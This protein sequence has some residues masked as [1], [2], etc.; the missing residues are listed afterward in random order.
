MISVQIIMSGASYFLSYS[1]Q[2]QNEEIFCEA[3][4]RRLLASARSSHPSAGLAASRSRLRSALL[5]PG[6]QR[7]NINVTN[8]QRA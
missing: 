5:I 2:D 6:D 1:L 3:L 8:M 4:Q 7:A